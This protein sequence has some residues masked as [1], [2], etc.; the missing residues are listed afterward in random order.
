MSRRSSVQDAVRLLITRNPYLYRGIRM[1]VIN[2]SAV[3]RFIHTDVENLAGSR[4]DP[5]TIVTAIMRFSNEIETSEQFD[6][7]SF[8]R[9]VRLSLET[10]IVVINVFVSEQNQS[11]LLLSLSELQKKGLSNK[12]H[13][14]PWSLRILTFTE[15]L[16]ET[17]EMLSGYEYELI[18]GVAELKLNLKSDDRRIDRIALLTDLL[19]RNGVHLIN[20]YYTQDEISLI[21]RDEDSSRAI[22]AIR[23]MISRVNR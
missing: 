6:R 21:I 13:Q 1:K 5:N 12:V 11:N 23:S 8:F 17:L 10:S 16:P 9:G 3:A 22:E 19:F 4:V 18:E 14:F 7:R 20:A 15:L 2:Y